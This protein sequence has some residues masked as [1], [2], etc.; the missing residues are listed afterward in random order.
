[1]RKNTKKK[2]FTLVELVIVLVILSVISAIAVPFFMNYWKKAE[3]QKNE[4]NAKTVY[5]AAESRLT[6]YRNSGQWEDFK[7]EILAEGMPYTDASQVTAEVTDEEGNG[8]QTVAQTSGADLKGRIYAITLDAKSQS[9][10]QN[11]DNPV[12]E[13]LEDYIYDTGF[14]DGSIAI[15]IDVVRLFCVLWNKVQRP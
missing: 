12:L 13:L 9:D 15:E 11:A 3:F 10:S 7:K 1:M 6:Y 5:L 4:A 8:L 2:G 14:F